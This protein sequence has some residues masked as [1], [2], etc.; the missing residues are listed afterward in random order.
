MFSVNSN[1]KKLIQKPLF[2]GILTREEEY[3]RFLFSPQLRM[4]SKENYLIFSSGQFAPKTEKHG[5]NNGIWTE[6]GTKFEFS[7]D[8]LS[9]HEVFGSIYIP[10]D[11]IIGR[12]RFF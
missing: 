9:K 2:K 3:Y 10:V 1:S 8:S 5:N 11:R 6:K 7:L 12:N 4:S